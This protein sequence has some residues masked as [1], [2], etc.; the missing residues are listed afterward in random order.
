MQD[1]NSKNFFLIASIFIPIIFG[2]ILPWSNTTPFPIWP[3]FTGI[4]MVCLAF[5]P[6][7]VRDTIFYPILKI[8]TFIGLINQFIIMLLVFVC[9]FVP[10]GLVRRI[11]GIDSLN[12]KSLSKDSFWRTPDEERI[13]FNH[14]F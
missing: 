9:I 13:N 3:Y 4:L 6:R 12:S 5:S 14:P 11:L 8:S 1:N 7:R 10:V 2:I